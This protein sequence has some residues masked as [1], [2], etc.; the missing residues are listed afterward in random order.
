MYASMSGVSVVSTAVPVPSNFDVVVCAIV[1]RSRVEAGCSGTLCMSPGIVTV[2]CAA[3]WSRMA[4]QPDSWPTTIPP[5]LH[6]YYSHIGDHRTE[7]FT[8][9]E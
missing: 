1:S 8:L 2:S 6:T 9:G 3:R 5:V 4:D 7:L